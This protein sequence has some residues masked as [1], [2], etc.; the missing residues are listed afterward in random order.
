MFNTNSSAALRHLAAKRPQTIDVVQSSPI[1]RRDNESAPLALEPLTKRGIVG[2]HCP[3]V[4]AFLTASEFTQFS[5]HPSGALVVN[6]AGLFE[7]H[8]YYVDKLDGITA[9]KGRRGGRRRG[10]PHGARGQCSGC[11]AACGSPSTVQAPTR[12]SAAGLQ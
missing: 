7:L 5:Q 11:C 10:D 12:G 1:A 8:L 2:L 3:T 6:A 9:A 4:D